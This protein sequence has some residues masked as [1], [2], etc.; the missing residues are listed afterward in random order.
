V[1]GGT[2]TVMRRAI[3]PDVP[4]IVALL[5]D[6]DLGRGR[7]DASAEALPRY[8]DAFA[9]LDRDPNQMPVV[10]LIEGRV[11]GYLQ[12]TFI[13]GLSRQGAWRGLIESVRIDK[14]LRGR[15]LGDKL[16]RFAIEECRA[17]GCKLVQL[18]TDKTRADAHR[19]YTRLGFVASHQGMKLGL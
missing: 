6:D 17:R 11:A 3:T 19:F 12:I 4:G 8:R 10:L 1:S 2:A 15:G 9:T 14:S 7:E 13:P 5:A 18:T 16:M